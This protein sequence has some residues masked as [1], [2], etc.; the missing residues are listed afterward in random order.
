M[1]FKNTI[2]LSA[3]LIIII[4]T[5][6]KVPFSDLWWQLAS[7]KYILENHFP[8]YDPFSYTAKNLFWL[9]H[10]WLSGIL[11]YLIYQFKGISGLYIFRTLILILTFY[12]IYQLSLKYQ[13]NFIS[14]LILA[15]NLYACGNLF[16][17]IRP[18][19]FTY[20]FLA[21]IIYLLENKFYSYLPLIFIFWVNLHAGFLAG[22]GILGIYFLSCFKEKKFLKNALLSFLV[23][24]LNP[25]HYKI[26]LYPFSFFKKTSFNYLIEWI[27]PV[28]TGKDWFFLLLFLASLILVAL[29]HKKIKL[30]DLLL[31]FSFSYLGFK[32]IRHIPLFS[33][34]NFYIFTKY[35]NSKNIKLKLNFYKM[36]SFLS[37]FS[38]IMILFLFFLKFASL[39][40]NF[41]NAESRWFPI[42][43]IKFLKLNSFKEKI[44]NPYEWGGYLIFNLYPKYQVFIDGRANTIYSEKIYKDCIKIMFAKKKWEEILKSYQIGLVLCNKIQISQGM[45]LPLKLKKNKNWKLVY[46]DEIC[47]IFK[48]RP[49]KKNIDYK[50]SFQMGKEAENLIL[51]GEF[52]EAQKLCYK[53]LLL[54]PYCASAYLDLG[55]LEIIQNGSEYKALKY[56]LKALN[57][58]PQSEISR[59]NLGMLYKNKGLI[60]SAESE[61]K[62]ALNCNPNFYPAKEALKNLNL[63]F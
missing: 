48:K 5:F 14:L 36:E 11:F 12:L 3:V 18:Y 47:L 59:Y 25:Y 15:I 31:F 9:N 21:L 41:L 42:E 6:S 63:K 53:I 17:D 13:N 23:C 43:A 27:P 2:N 61:F 8:F 40:L 1:K 57:L 32:A 51:K 28:I 46:E 35:L 19:I 30:N 52:K 20:L 10:E 33:L 49:L 34:V 22:L 24:F 39:N 62:A 26:F 37:N 58:N 55:Y 60:K 54:F 45:I 7:G 50:N 56:F 44:F 29:N 16:F 38:L 4:F